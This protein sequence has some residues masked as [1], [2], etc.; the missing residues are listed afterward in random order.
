MRSE[1][2]LI[3]I[4]DKDY[5]KLKKYG[6]K[7]DLPMTEVMGNALDKLEVKKVATTKEI[8]FKEIKFDVCDD[9]EAEVPSD[10]AFCPYC[11][12]EFDEDEDEDDEDEDDEEED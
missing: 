9:C 4:R 2:R 8:K 11:G 7:H 6:E 5:A 3:R 10:A 12:V 1:D